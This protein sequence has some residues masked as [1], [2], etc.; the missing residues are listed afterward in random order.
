MSSYVRLEREDQRRG[1]Q[2]ERRL[3]SSRI[4]DTGRSIGWRDRAGGADAS[5]R[6]TPGDTEPMST[7]QIRSAVIAVT[8]A[9]ACSVAIVHPRQS[10]AIR[11]PVW[12]IRNFLGGLR[13]RG[14][15]PAWVG[16]QGLEVSRI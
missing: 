11:W 4:L 9:E 8:A 5:V 7:R 14:R 3:E 16:L 10:R 2:A 12:A 15:I 6:N 13:V 1:S